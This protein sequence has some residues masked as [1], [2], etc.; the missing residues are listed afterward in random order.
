MILAVVGG[1]GGVVLLYYFSFFVLELLTGLLAYGLEGERP[2]DLW[3]L[4][5][6]RIYYRELMYY[7][8]ARSILHA[9]RGHIVGWGKL[10]RR[11]TVTLA[12]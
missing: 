7:V 2:G 9:M 3:L 4:F 6:Q 12:P 1:N 5:F 10:E 11:A 8:L